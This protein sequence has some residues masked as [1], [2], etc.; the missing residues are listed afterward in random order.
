MVL[1][2]RQFSFIWDWPEIQKSEIPSPN[3]CL[4]SGDWGEL[5]IPNLPRTSLMKCYWRLQNARVTAFAVFELLRE[6]QQKGRGG[7]LKLPPTHI[8]FKYLAKFI[9]KRLCQSPF[10]QWSCRIKTCNFIKKRLRHKR[11]PVNFS[12]KSFLAKELHYRCSTGY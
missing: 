11:F 8:R 3:F 7:T 9:K 10:I 1:E 6:N 12:K 4:I 2:L 5:E